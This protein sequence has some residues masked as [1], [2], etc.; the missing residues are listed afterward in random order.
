[1]IRHFNNNDHK[2]KGIDYMEDIFTVLLKICQMEHLFVKE[3]CH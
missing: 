3:A 2:N 1:M